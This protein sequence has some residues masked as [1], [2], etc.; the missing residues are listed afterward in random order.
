MYGTSTLQAMYI[1]MLENLYTYSGIMVEERESLKHDL[2]DQKNEVE[3]QMLDKMEDIITKVLQVGL[4]FHR[5]CKHCK[6]DLV[7]VSSLKKKIY[8]T[9][10][11]KYT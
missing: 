1:G 2:R 8:L 3:A 7:Q 9:G 11:L 4:C 10:K 6:A 5:H